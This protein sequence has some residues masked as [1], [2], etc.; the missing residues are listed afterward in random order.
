MAQR[1]K[2]DTRTKLY[3]T[4]KIMAVFGLVGL[5]GAGFLWAERF[6][7]AR[8][9][10][11]A[12]D[13]VFVDKPTWV[14]A[15]LLS[16]VTDTVG[17]R[18]YLQPG[19]AEEVSTILNRVPWLHEI[20]V[21][22]SHETVRVHAQWRKPLATVKSGLVHFCVDRDLV[23][24]DALDLALPTVTVRGVRY[25]HKPA[26]G[27]RLEKEDLAAAVD[28]IAI[29]NGMDEQQAPAPPLLA[30]IDTL[31]ISNF[32]GREAKQASHIILTTKEKTR[33]EW[34]AEIGAWGENLENSDTRKLARLY[35]T[36]KEL[37]YSFGA[38]QFIINLKDSPYEV[39]FPVDQY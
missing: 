29:L 28:L 4:L 11:Q 13:L 6:V 19:V 2:N 8:R 27:S 36:F 17:K 34:G 18:F 9:P 21:E 25:R 35:T 39:P 12:G 22:V 20:S 16:R 5:V 3:A 10:G 14:D 33:I 31:D 15:T 32:R 23:V 24:L 1:K 26:I 7:Q 30:Q 38:L 37:N